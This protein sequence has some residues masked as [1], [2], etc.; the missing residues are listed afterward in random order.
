MPSKSAFGERS[1]ILGKLLVGVAVM[2]LALGSG[3]AEAEDPYYGWCDEDA[4]PNYCVSESQWCYQSMTEPSPYCPGC[5]PYYGYEY[6]W[7]FCWGPNYE[8]YYS[9]ISD[10]QNMQADMCP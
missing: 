10:C 4:C 9:C 2:V 3:L 8:V 5:P 7:N 6:A 1:R